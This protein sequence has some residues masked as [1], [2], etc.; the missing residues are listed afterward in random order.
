MPGSSKTRTCIAAVSVALALAA[1]KPSAQEQDAAAAATPDAATASASPAPADSA[2]APASGDAREVLRGMFEKL[3]AVRSYQIVTT[4]DDGD[5]PMDGTTEFVAPD[6]SRMTSRDGNMVVTV[7]GQDSYTTV[8]GKTTKSTLPPDL[9]D[10]W[11][12]PAARDARLASATIE[13]QG[14]EVIDGTPT[15]KYLMHMTDPVEAEMTLWIGK[16]GLPVQ[17]HVSVEPFPGQKTGSTMRYSRFNDPAI[18][19]EAPQ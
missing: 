18:Q 1:C 10:P 5:G 9:V 2:A 11:R 12:D 17:Q 7:I 16:D 3:A 14:D 19:V 6:R 4:S 15:H 13:D 8:Q